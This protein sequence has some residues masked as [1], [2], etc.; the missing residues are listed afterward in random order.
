[1][2]FWRKLKVY[3]SEQDGALGTLRNFLIRGALFM[4]PIAITV[5]IIKYA[6]GF[7]DTYLGGPTSALIRLVAPHWLLSIFPDGSIPGMSMILL[8]LVLLLL[9]AIASWPFGSQGLRIVDVVMLKIPFI[10]GIYSST[11]K[12]VD[13]FGDG[14][15]FQRAVWFEPH[16]HARALGF[17]TH[18]FIEATSGEKYLVIFYMWVPNPS[19]GELFT[20]PE[21][22]TT[23]CDINP[24]EV[25]TMLLSMGTTM[26][27]HVSILPPAPPPVQE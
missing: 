15:R 7:V 12:M 11:R 26:P 19:S 14:S 18:E 6:L 27:E 3:S 20:L 24:S 21:R 10:G 13:S 8:A 23:P 22:L 9:G 1:M 2:K 16:P 5:L 25:F 4:L 17:V